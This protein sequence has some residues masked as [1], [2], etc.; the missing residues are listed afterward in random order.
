[1]SFKQRRNGN[2]NASMKKMLRDKNYSIHH[3]ISVFLPSSSL[4]NL[5]P[6]LDPD[7][8]NLCIHPSLQLLQG[9][10]IIMESLA[11]LL[12]GQIDTLRVEILVGVTIQTVEVRVVDTL[13]GHMHLRKVVEP[14]MGELGC[15]VLDP[16]V[17]A[18]EWATQITHSRV[19]L[20]VERQVVEEA[21]TWVV[22][23]TLSLDG[24]NEKIVKVSTKKS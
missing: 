12:E 8:I 16:E 3:P 10:A 4:G 19:P 15:L 9:Q 21:T 17:V 18:M 1:M 22:T 5:I 20:M 14:H 24:L 13:V 7:P 6:S 11:D 2:S 23:V